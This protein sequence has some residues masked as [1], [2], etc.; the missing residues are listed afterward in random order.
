MQINKCVRIDCAL[1]SCALKIGRRSSLP[2]FATQV[3]C[4]GHRTYSCCSSDQTIDTRYTVKSVELAQ[5][6][7]RFVAHVFS[8]M[9]KGGKKVEHHILGRLSTR[10]RP[11][12][13]LFGIGFLNRSQSHFRD[14]LLPGTYCILSSLSPKRDFRTEM[15]NFPILK[16]S[17]AEINDHPPTLMCE[18]TALL[19]RFR[20][21]VQS[22]YH[23]WLCGLINC[24]FKVGA[25][26]SFLLLLLSS[27]PYTC[28]TSYSA[29]CT[30]GTSPTSA[31]QSGVMP[32]PM[33]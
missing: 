19:E 33:L 12:N 6:W 8:T 18:F 11:E 5:R 7:D 30:S 32:M 26:R 15:V 24:L 17:S 27:C 13:T 29:R 28:R 1:L 14:K 9:D 23:T 3:Q 25:L 16:E 21:D 22:R 2:L 10:S 4:T 20:N 31:Q